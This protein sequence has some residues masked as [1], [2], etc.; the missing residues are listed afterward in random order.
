MAVKYPN[1]EGR[2]RIAMEM[3]VVY[4]PVNWLTILQE[5]RTDNVTG[6]LPQLRAKLGDPDKTNAQLAK[7]FT[8]KLG[9]N[10]T[11]RQI[12]KWRNRQI[13]EPVA[14]TSMPKAGYRSNR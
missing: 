14:G 3:N 10:V 2:A 6:E 11:S 9:G 4:P 12:S 8:E 1:L 13:P 7:E 5:D